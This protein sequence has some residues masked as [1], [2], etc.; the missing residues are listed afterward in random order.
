[1]LIRFSGP[2]LSDVALP[3]TEPQPSNPSEDT[4]PEDTP[5]EDIPSEDIPSKDAPSEDSPSE[6]TPSEDAPEEPMV[7][8][9]PEGCTYILADG[10]EISAGNEVRSPAEDGDRLV[11]KMYEYTYRTDIDGWKA[12]TIASTLLGCDPFRAEI[13]CKPLISLAGIFAGD[14]FLGECPEIP[15]TVTDLRYAFYNCSSLGVAPAIPDSVIDMES[16]FLG[17]VGLLE[18]P[19]IPASVKNMTRTFAGCSN[20]NGEIVIHATPTTFAECFSP[21][22]T[23]YSVPPETIVILTGAG[24]N[25]EDLAA[26]SSAGNVTVDPALLSENKENN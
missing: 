22:V 12:A 9:V 19:E 23:D 16:T 14:M 2:T 5:P 4:P 11:D 15:D 24:G 25:L 1:M 26:T 21:Y 6:D 13:N 20:L 10:T 8:I 3:P 7:Y 17:C 18:A